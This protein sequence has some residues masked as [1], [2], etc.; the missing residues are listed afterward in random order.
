MKW[1]WRKNDLD[2]REMCAI[3]LMLTS[4]TLTEIMRVIW[5][6]SLQQVVITQMRCSSSLRVYRAT[7]IYCDNVNFV[8]CNI[9]KDTKMHHHGRSRRSGNSGRFALLCTSVTSESPSS[10]VLGLSCWG[11]CRRIV[12]CTTC[13]SVCLISWRAIFNNG[14]T[15]HRLFSSA[16]CSRVPPCRLKRTGLVLR[17]FPRI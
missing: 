11:T 3:I 4:R 6:L 14:Q 10:L 17:G 9:R 8:D 1:H 5:S 2:R 7:S 15:S 12:A 16:V 13:L